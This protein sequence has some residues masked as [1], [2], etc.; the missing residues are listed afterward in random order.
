MMLYAA[1]ICLISTKNTGNKS[2]LNEILLR[3]NTFSF[4]HILVRRYIISWEI[5]KYWILLVF[6]SNLLPFGWFLEEEE[7]EKND[8]SN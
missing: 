1:R 5:R 7:G 3:T 8:S 6:C 2:L 4:Y